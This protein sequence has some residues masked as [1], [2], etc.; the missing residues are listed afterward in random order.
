MKQVLTK[1]AIALLTFAL[2]VTAASIW[3]SKPPSAVSNPPP[4]KGCQ[5]AFE[6]TLLAKAIHE[7]GDPQLFKAFQEMPLYMM[8]GRVDEAY[9]LIWIPAFHPPALVRVWRVGNRSFMVAK[10]LDTKGWSKFGNVGESYARTVTAFEWRDF[11]NLVDRADFW[12]L[13]ESTEEVIPQDGAMWIID[14]VKSRE[15]HR[16]RRRLPKDEY[17]EMCKH[18]IRLS[19]LETAH[20]LYLP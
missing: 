17:A 8:P 19:G 4:S 20:S 16:V 9:S 14:G 11:T 13:P 7:D 6:P 10:T 2:G 5:I 1:A 3:I 15:Y 12:E 18:L